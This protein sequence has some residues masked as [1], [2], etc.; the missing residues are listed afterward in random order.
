MSEEMKPRREH[1]VTQCPLCGGEDLQRGWTANIGR[2]VHQQ[3]KCENCGKY[4]VG[5]F[6]FANFAP[7]PQD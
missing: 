4:F 6:V 3:I 1:E 5:V 2:Q 7:L